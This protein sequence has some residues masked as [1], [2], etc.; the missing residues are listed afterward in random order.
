MKVGDYDI[1]VL[2]GGAFGLD[3]G[4]MFGIIPKPLWSKH[5]PADDR[6]R[7]DL[8]ARTLLIRGHDRN[9]L[10]DTGLGDKW[11]DKHR[12]IYKINPASLGI[13]KA[14]VRVGL[15]PADITDVILT[16]LHFDHAGGATREEN[17]ELVP[18]FPRATYYVQ[19]ENWEWANHPSPKDAGS[20]RKENFVPLQEHG[21]LE[22]VEG[23]EE[24]FPGI[25]LLRSEGHTKAQQLPLI[26]GEVN[27]VFYC[28][29]LIPTAAHIPLAW[30]MGYDNFPLQIIEEKERVL[31]Q[32][33]AE[34]WTLLL[35]HD[36][37][38]AA[39]TVRRTEQGV[40]AGERVPL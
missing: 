6:N 5:T 1:S 29:D 7:I 22:F 23:E 16:H 13:N 28:G 24:L 18:T 32:A 8:I 26:R 2:N 14:L 37:G 9:M 40:E 17:G 27:T 38:T 33:A 34:H 36:P 19:R 15:T 35:E 30:G 39:V 31:Q 3:G 12:D 20:Y 21:V 25:R 11:S 4:A 10:V